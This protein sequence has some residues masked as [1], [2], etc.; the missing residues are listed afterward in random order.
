MDTTT[1]HHIPYP[2]PAD[3]PNIPADM[4]SL[5]EK[6]DDSLDNTLKV[7]PDTAGRPTHASG[8][9]IYQEDVKKL[10]VSDGATW[11]EVSN[12][13]TPLVN[14]PTYGWIPRMRSG[15]VVATFDQNGIG[16]CIVGFV[17]NIVGPEKYS[18]TFFNNN[19]SANTAYFVGHGTAATDAVQVKYVDGQVGGC[20][21]SWIATYNS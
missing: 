9:L 4:Q 12:L 15:Q 10:Y 18:Y 7:V 6:V 20:G 3:V 8:R 21:I 5:A 14:D 17:T 19:F 11:L 2:E 1:V 13:G 16:S